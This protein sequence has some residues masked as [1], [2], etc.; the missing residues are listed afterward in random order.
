MCGKYKVGDKVVISEYLNVWLDCLSTVV[1]DMVQY[2]GR[3]ATIVKIEEDN[4]YKLDVDRCEWEWNA[5]MFEGLYSPVRYVKEETI[6]KMLNEA[7]VLVTTA[8]DTTTVVT[9]RLKNGFTITEASGC[10]DP[11]NYNQEIGAEICMAKIEDKLWML[12]GYALN[13]KI[14]EV[15]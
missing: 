3:V 5:E 8:F 15:E 12:E 14:S 1:D 6:K 2:K 10:I 11:K 13:K 9:V 7:D 4:V